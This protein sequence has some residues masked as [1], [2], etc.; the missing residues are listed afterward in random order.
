MVTDVKFE[1]VEGT[2]IVTLAKAKKQIRVEA[3]FV[4]EDDLIQSYIDAAIGMSENYISGHIVEKIMIMKLNSFDN[5]IVFEAFPIQGIENINYFPLNGT[6]A[7]LMPSANYDLISVNPKVSKISF[8][9]V[10]ETQERFDA[11]TVSVKLGFADG[12][13]PKPVIQAILLQIA[14]MYDRREDRSE[15]LST[16]AMSLLRPYKKF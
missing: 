10:P 13:T 5:P 9:T 1:V 16:A 4:E 12:K 15:I 3:S 6:D 7:L 8:K 14:D 2:E 11:V